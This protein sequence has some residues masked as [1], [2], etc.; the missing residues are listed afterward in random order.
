M[1]AAN[2]AFQIWKT[3]SACFFFTMLSLLFGQTS[4]KGRPE[5]DVSLMAG[6]LN[7][8]IVNFGIAK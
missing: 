5:R 8:S 7:K 2:G 1:T 4:N 6:F 3:S